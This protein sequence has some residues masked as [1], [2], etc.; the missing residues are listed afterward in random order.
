MKYYFERED[1]IIESDEM[2]RK[3]GTSKAIPELTIYE[4]SVQPSYDPVSFNRLA[5]G[6]FYPVESYTQVKANAIAALV[7]AGLTQAEAESAVG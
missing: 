6:T 4:L 7:S 1:R 2:I 5:N 3:Y